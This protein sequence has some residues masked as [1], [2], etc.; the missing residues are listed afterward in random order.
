MLT[1]DRVDNI[2]GVRGIGEVKA[3]KL[4][5]DKN[6]QEMWETCVELLGY[7]RAVENGHLLYM[8]RHK[9]DTFTPPQELCTQT[10]CEV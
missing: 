6:E 10:P 7:D 4:L 2:V 8:L 5:K 3:E 1:G 9:D